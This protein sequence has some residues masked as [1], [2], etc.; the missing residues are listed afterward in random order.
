M[1]H[2]VMAVAFSL[3]MPPEDVLDMPVTWYSRCLAYMKIQKERHG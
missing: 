3:H 1:L 2:N